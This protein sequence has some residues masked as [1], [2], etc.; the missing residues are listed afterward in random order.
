MVKIIPVL[1]ANDSWVDYPLQDVLVAYN[2]TS[3]GVCKSGKSLKVQSPDGVRT[4][5]LAKK[6]Q[7]KIN[8]S[9][10][11]NLRVVETTVDGETFP[12]AFIPGDGKQAAWFSLDEIF[13]AKVTGKTV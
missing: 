6:D 9:D 7:G 11:T 13:N 4:I 12:V 1:P 2:A 5:A 10:F 3:A 8:T